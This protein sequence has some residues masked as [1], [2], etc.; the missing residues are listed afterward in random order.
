MNVLPV[1][2]ICSLSTLTSI[3][4]EHRYSLRAKSYQFHYEFRVLRNP[5]FNNEQWTGASALSTGKVKYPLN[6]T[7][8]FISNEG[9]PSINSLRYSTWSNSPESKALQSS[10]FFLALATNSAAMWSGEILSGPPRR[11]SAS[12][13]SEVPTRRMLRNPVQFQ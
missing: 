10:G 12:R 8:V 3:I 6:F 2:P 1:T 11:S 7:P 5:R 9:H 4:Y 13:G